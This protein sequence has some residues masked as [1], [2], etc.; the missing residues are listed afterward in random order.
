[1]KRNIYVAQQE[2]AG[3]NTEDVI[4]THKQKELVKKRKKE[5]KREKYSESQGPTSTISFW[6][7]G[8]MIR[9]MQKLKK[10]GKGKNAL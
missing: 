8:S 9:K 4:L 10:V 3:V 2:K 1:M 7:G 6:V 5:R